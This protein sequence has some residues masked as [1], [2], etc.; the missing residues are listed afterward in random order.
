[1]AG[2][3]KKICFT[4]NPEEHTSSASSLSIDEDMNG[5]LLSDLSGDQK[6]E[7]KNLLKSKNSHFS[8][9]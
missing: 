8:V 7:D 2:Q 5:L 3:G 4:D 9:H 1:M 6:L